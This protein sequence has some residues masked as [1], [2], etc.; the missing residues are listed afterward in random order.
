MSTPTLNP[1][2]LGRAENAHRAL[3]EHLLAGTG[4]AYQRWVALTLVAVSDQARDLDVLDRLVSALKID[5]GAA[6]AVIAGLTAAGLL[7]LSGGELRLSV[8]G[9]S[10]YDRIRTAADGTVADLYRDIPDGDL[11]VTGRVLTQIT[12]RADAK[13]EALKQEPAKTAASS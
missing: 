4:L 12:A 9:R 8:A 5:Q 2:I 6:R 11:E 10:L 3:L 13:L 7:S 1:R